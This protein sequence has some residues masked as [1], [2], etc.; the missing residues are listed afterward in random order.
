MHVAKAISD[1]F[2][3]LTANE[4]MGS[5]MQL[6]PSFNSIDQDKIGGSIPRWSAMG[7]PAN[8]CKAAGPLGMMGHQRCIGSLEGLGGG[9]APRSSLPG[10]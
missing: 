9:R 1:I 5:G 10:M 4:L 8:G 2:I 7:A 6:F 3:S